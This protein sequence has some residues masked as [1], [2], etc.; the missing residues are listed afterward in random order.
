MHFVF[1]SQPAIARVGQAGL[2]LEVNFFILEGKRHFARSV[3]T[4]A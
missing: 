2:I 1:Q 3:P 4:A